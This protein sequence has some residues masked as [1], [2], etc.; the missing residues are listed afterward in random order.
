MRTGVG[1]TQLGRVVVGKIDSSVAERTGI[2]ITR[3]DNTVS[4]LLR[5]VIGL[6]ELAAEDGHETAAI[7]SSESESLANAGIGSR[8]RST[9]REDTVPKTTLMHRG[10]LNS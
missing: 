1:R 10:P 6:A 8:V 3:Q 5:P 9:I 2:C 7:S 4:L